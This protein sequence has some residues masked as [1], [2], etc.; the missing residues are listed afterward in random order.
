M[1]SRFDKVVVFDHPTG[2]PIIP[3]SSG[4]RGDHKDLRSQVSEPLDLDMPRPLG[5]NH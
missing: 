1:F 4:C 3:E 5:R 2:T